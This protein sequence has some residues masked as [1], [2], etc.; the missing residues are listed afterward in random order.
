MQV[1]VACIHCCCHRY[2]R[3][4]QP[5]AC[6]RSHCAHARRDRPPHAVCAA[7][8]NV[9]RSQAS[10]LPSP[11]TSRWLWLATYLQLSAPV[12]HLVGANAPVAFSRGRVLSHTPSESTSICL[13]SQ[14]SASTRASR[15]VRGHASL[16]FGTPSLSA[17]TTASDRYPAAVTSAIVHATTVHRHS[18]QRDFA[19]IPW[20]GA[21]EQRQGGSRDEGQSSHV[22][23]SRV[24]GSL[25]ES[26]GHVVWGLVLRTPGCALGCP[27]FRILPPLFTRGRC[28]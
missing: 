13:P 27:A 14:P 10:P 1:V 26:E 28:L 17:S 4:V 9:P 22:S 8:R 19:F 2:H 3:Y 11:S 12:H 15:V 24:N 7:Q 25:C 16:L 6:N 18:A 21:V 5:S 23:V 20:R